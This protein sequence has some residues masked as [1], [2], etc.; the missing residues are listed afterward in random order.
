MRPTLREDTFE[1]IESVK[2][3]VYG[4]AYASPPGP[5]PEWEELPEVLKA[6]IRECK[7]LHEDRNFLRAFREVLL[8]ALRAGSNNWTAWIPKLQ[9]A[10]GPADDELNALRERVKESPGEENAETAKRKGSKRPKRSTQRGEGEAKLTSALTKHHQYA[11]DCCMN[12]E[13][14]GNN[15]LARLAG[16]WPSTASAFFE[17]KFKGYVKYRVVCRDAGRLLE[18]LKALNGDFAPHHLYGRRPPNEDDRDRTK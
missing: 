5:V 12:L 4:D 2:R 11:E 9:A 6:I 13:P 1:A 10:W 14:V 3:R 7:R 17:K 15:E 16:V 18:S 8:G